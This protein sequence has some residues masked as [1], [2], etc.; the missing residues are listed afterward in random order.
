MAHGSELRAVLY[1]QRFNK[2]PVAT[3]RRVSSFNGGGQGRLACGLNR[4]TRHREEEEVVVAIPKLDQTPPE[5]T[6]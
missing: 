6:F 1:L 5:R 3:G 2:G 4:L